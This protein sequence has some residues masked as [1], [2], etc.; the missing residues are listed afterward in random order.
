M[1]IIISKSILENIL[2]HTQAFLEKKDTSQITSHLLFEAR[3]NGLIIKATDYEIGLNIQTTQV[4][5]KEI[6]NVTASGKKLLDIIRI[7]KDEAITLEIRQ[8]TL[9]ILQAHS[10]FKLPTFQSNEFPSFPSFEGKA[11]ITIDSQTLIS[12]LKKIT[13]ATDTNNPKFEL[14]G[15]LI[16]IQSSLINFVATDTRRLALVNVENQSDRELSIIIPKKAIVEIQKLFFDN[17][18]IIY[19]ETHLIIKSQHYNFF[20]KLINGKFPDYTRIIPKEIKNTLILPKS[21]IINAIKQITTI[22]N[23]MKITFTQNLISFESLSDDNIEAKTEMDFNTNFTEPFVLAVN[24]RYILDFLAQI[25][26]SQFNIG[27][28]EPN[29]PF[30]LQDENFKTIIMPIVI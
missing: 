11:N 27:L 17:I 16:D 7:L 6:G 29:L 28:N 1:K 25:P 22:S 4:E 30:V 10:K 12:S 3:Q 15:A 5:I 14:N 13:S 2:I 24:S 21:D 18:E 19:D 20:T 26:N 23:D 8:D 9:H